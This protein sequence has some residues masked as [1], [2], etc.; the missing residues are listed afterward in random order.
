MKIKETGN[1]QAF[2]LEHDGATT[3]LLFTELTI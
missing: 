1:F 3:L 2:E